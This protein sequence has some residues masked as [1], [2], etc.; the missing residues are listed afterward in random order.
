M[1]NTFHVRKGDLQNIRVST[2]LY[3]KD[4]P[5]NEIGDWGWDLGQKDAEGTISE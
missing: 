3:R 2:H 5:E 4:K 1:K